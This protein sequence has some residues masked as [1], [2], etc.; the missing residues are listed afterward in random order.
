MNLGKTLFVQLME[1]VPWTS[2]ACIVV[3]YGGDARVRSLI[4]TEQF[5]T[6]AFAQLTCHESLLD[7]EEKSN[8][9]YART[10]SWRFAIRSFHSDRRVR[11]QEAAKCRSLCRAAIALRAPRP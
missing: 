3:R 6:M 10:L 2:F 9:Y 11:A 7:I 8:R 5:R 4:C 1:F